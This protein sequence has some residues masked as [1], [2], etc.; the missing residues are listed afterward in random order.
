M[1]TK[2][3]VTLTLLT[4][5]PLLAAVDQ[6][7]NSLSDVYEF[8]YFG[9]PN[10]PFADPDGDGVTTYDAMFWGTN[11]PRRLQS[12]ERPRHAAP[13]SISEQRPPSPVEMKLERATALT[14]APLPLS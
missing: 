6:N 13:E 5:T 12:H 10:A 14:P 11:H 2:V 8:I 3:F 1:K 9:G 7:N 4:A